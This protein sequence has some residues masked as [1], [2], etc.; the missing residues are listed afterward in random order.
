MNDNHQ[1]AQGNNEASGF[2][3]ISDHYWRAFFEQTLE[4]MLIMDDQGKCIDV[5]PAACELLGV[6][7]EALLGCKIS[8][9]TESGVDFA[10]A[11]CRFLEQGSMK[12][13]FR[14]ISHDGTVHEAN[15]TAIT[16]FL[17]H[18]HLSILQ[19]ITKH[20][21][22]KSAQQHSE[23]LA[24]IN[25]QLR[26]E[27]RER[28]EIEE[29]LRKTQ[30]F[31]FQILDT[32]PDP[33]FVKNEDHQWLI[34]N[35]PCCK[36]I[37]IP[38]EELIGKTDYD[39]FPEEEAVVFWEKDEQVLSTGV[40]D[41]NE[42]YLTNAQ[43]ETRII[44]TKKS[45]LKDTNGNK[46]IVGV[47]RDIND[48]KL[49][50]VALKESEERF[51]SMFEQ[52]AVGTV[53]ASLTGRFLQV[54]Q[55]FCELVGYSN[56]EL[57]NLGYKDIIYPDDQEEEIKFWQSL[58]RGEISS[59]SQEKRYI[60]KDSSLVWI[61]VTTSLMRFPSDEPQYVAGVV[62]D[63]NRRK[64]AEEFLHCREQQFRAL[65]ENSPDI[66]A[67]YNS[68]IK[69]LYVNPAMEKATGIAQSIFIGKTH[70][71]LNLPSEKCPLWDEAVQS[72][73]LTGEERIIEF[74]FL[75]PYG[76]RFYQSHLVSE[77]NQEGKIDSVLGMSRDITESKIAGET[78]RLQAEREGLLRALQDRIR[79]SLEVNE[80]L[81]TTVSEVRNLL[82]NDRVLLFKLCEDGVGRV[83]VESVADGLPETV[84]MEFYDELFPEE[85][86]E[87]YCQGHPRVINNI[88]EDQLAPCLKEF[89]ESLGV[90]SKLVIPILYNSELVE[91]DDRCLLKPKNYLWGVMTLHDCSGLRQ[92]QQWEINLLSY[93][94]NQLGI[95]LQQSELY[96]KLEGELL[97]RKRAEVALQQ[98][99]QAAEV[100]NRAKSEFL[101]NIS[102]ELR[103]PLNGILGHAQILKQDDNL[104]EP[105]Q[106]S[107]KTIYQCG[108]H[109]L[110][111][112]DDIL[113][114]S[115]VEAQKLELYRT[116]FNFQ[117]FI[118]TLVELFRMRAQQKGVVFSY[119]GI[120][121]LPPIIVADEKRL[122]QVLMNLLSNAIKFTTHGMVTFKVSFAGD[123]AADS[124]LLETGLYSSVVKV[125]FQV[126]DTGIG[127]NSSEFEEIFLPFCQVGDRFRSTEGTGLGLAISQKLVQLMDSSIHVS[128]RLGEGSI[129]WFDLDVPQVSGWPESCLLKSRRLVGFKGDKRRVLIVDDNQ[130][131]RLFLRELLERFGL[132][133]FEVVDGQDC[134]NQ[135][136]EYQ[137][138][139]ILMDL[140][141]P[142]IDGFETARRLQQLPLNDV[143]LIA[144]S[145]SAFGT[146]HQ[147]TLAAGFQDF[148]PK[149]VQIKHLLELIII[150]LGVE[151]IYEEFLSATDVEPNLVMTSL[152]TPPQE[153]LLALS[154]LAQMGDISGLLNQ[155][156]QLEM[157]DNKLVP[158][159]IQMRQLAKGFKLK[160]LLDFLRQCQER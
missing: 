10:Q 116:E 68:D 121:G 41:E 2:Y 6:L 91:Q 25:E 115:K 88:A 76:L 100:A 75:T 92:W 139:L 14:L 136:L 60:R 18:C 132:D 157:L 148:L 77:V 44:S 51:R 158:F 87:L 84:G 35:E 74:D 133:V 71:E 72:V 93:L 112:I 8:S 78:L 5:N 94:G 20:K 7:R 137:P 31:L 59:Y 9:F 135:V 95:A 159:A 30:K 134:L 28:R 140:V 145:A 124:R 153:E 29:T 142:G 21:Q 63:I 156:D 160:Q 83:V 65:V 99:K 15:F 73:F 11:W 42:E 1:F 111:L 122:R 149:P 50:E 152:I 49:A 81:N 82:N 56:S 155:A 89:L 4:P 19:D 147:D 109:L 108:K 36:F 33:V 154:Q 123:G 61:K 23:E 107:L 69:F 38:R 34:L 104:L 47:I 97:E 128:S 26:Q 98:A 13:K 150:H 118:N 54:N 22:E 138:N 117:G 126:E 17:P 58:L 12:E 146:T 24:Q 46:I 55:K 143:V 103:T 85:C 27:I 101:T 151:G 106:K 57:L 43:G 144:L 62:E 64:Q 96:Q 86:Y 45:L 110:T 130:V 120:S 39:L 16:N 129:F 67:R 3:D 102:H 70:Q 114:L 40:D 52:A 66:I 48:Q 32:I 37:G 119:E 113:D 131:N 80:V 105:Q 90:K 79:Q 127:I 125:R 141:M 53:I